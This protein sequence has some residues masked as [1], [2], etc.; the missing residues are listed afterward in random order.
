M[1]EHN[2]SVELP[3]K[4]NRTSV[5]LYGVLPNNAYDV[6]VDVLP[7]CI[8]LPAESV[9]FTVPINGQLDLVTFM[10]ISKFLFCT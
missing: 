2:V 8:G 4:I 6:H 5:T 7:M 3:I 10:E 1:I 9:S